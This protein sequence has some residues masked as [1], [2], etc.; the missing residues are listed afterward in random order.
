MKKQ[1][2]KKITM[3]AWILLNG[4][5]L[6]ACVTDPIQ[7]SIDQQRSAAKKATVVLNDKPASSAVQVIQTPERLR[8]VLYSDRCFEWSGHRHMRPVC[9]KQLD[10]A[11]DLLASYGSGPIKVIAYTD[12]MYDTKTAANI[13]QRQANITAAFLW[14]RGIPSMSL[15]AI[16]RGR[17]DFVANNRDINASAANRRVEIVRAKQRT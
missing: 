2:L 9:M 10:K 1:I 4:A 15:Q 11:L 14:S 5:F 6:T 3:G 13:A 7:Q 16:G 12:D 8:I 17:H